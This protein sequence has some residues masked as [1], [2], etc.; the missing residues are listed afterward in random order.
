MIERHRKICAAIGYRPFSNLLL[1]DA[2]DD[3]DGPSIGHID[4]DLACIRVDLEAF[5][6]R[7]QRDVTNLA[8]D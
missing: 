1:R 4:K 2:I 5:G 8:V 7:L 6:M 3:G